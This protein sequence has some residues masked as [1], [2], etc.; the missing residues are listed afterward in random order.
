MK[1]T[2]SEED[3]IKF[4]KDSIK[5]LREKILVGSTT[6]QNKLINFKHSDK[7]RGYTR[8]VDELPNRV[9]EDLTSGKT[10]I[11]KS[12]PEPDFEPKD[13]RTREFKMEFQRAQKEDDVYL[14]KVEKMGDDYDG[15]SKE[16]LELE[17]ELNSTD[18]DAF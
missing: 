13:E 3:K 9:F 4:A 14:K 1:K 12:L 5:K 6:N 18:T 2:N 15:V 16:S 7:S 10:Y 8:I 11:F 17:R